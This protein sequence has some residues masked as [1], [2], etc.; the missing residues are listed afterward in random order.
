MIIDTHHHLWDFNETDYGWMDDSMKVL[1]RSYLPGEFQEEILKAG[2]GGTI[3][4]QARQMLEETLWLLDLSDRH[5]FIKGVVGW[6]DL[7]AEDLEDQLEL[8]SRHPRLV[9]VR[10]VIHDEADDEFMLRPSFLRGIRTLGKFKLTYDLL[11]FPRHL[12]RAHKLVKLFPEQ[13]FVLDHM[14]KPFI[15][16]GLL[17][18]WQE[19]LESLSTGDNVWCKVSGMVTEGDLKSWKFED[20][21]PYME[22]AFKAFG[23]ERILLGSDW[24]VCKLAGEYEQVLQIPLTFTEQMSDREKER[25]YY[26]NALECYQ[27]EN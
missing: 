26:K 24:P 18:P 8:L 2:V 21:V 10:H 7:C 4:V 3:V 16:K 22:A 19:E 20:F 17:T 1:K 25:I 13:R 15:R 9:G 27:L 11:L 5:S 12:A 23:T 14:A 6:V